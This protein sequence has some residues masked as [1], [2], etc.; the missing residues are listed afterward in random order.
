[1]GWGRNGSNCL[2]SLYYARK[3]SREWFSLDFG[4]YTNLGITSIEM[5]WLSSQ[6]KEVKQ[7]QSI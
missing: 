5:E 3:E 2:Q 6:G 1:M 4:W 7:I